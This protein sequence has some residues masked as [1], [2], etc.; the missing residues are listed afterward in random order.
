MLI[1]ISP[2]KTLDFESALPDALPPVT[3][4]EFS[5]D[6]GRLVRRLRELDTDSVAGLMHLSPALARLNVERYRSWQ[7]RA[8]ASGGRQAVLAFRGDVYLGLRAED[9]D[10]AD[11]AFAQQ[12]LRILSGLYGVLRPLDAIQPH[13]VEMGTPLDTGRSRG[14]YAWWGKRIALALRRQAVA[15]GTTTLVNLASQEYFRAVDA[16]AL[17]LR[18]VTPVFKE[19]RAGTL[20]IVSFSAKR[21]RGAMAG[22]AIRGRITD[23]DEL[24]GFAE[25]GYRFHPELS[26][27]DDWVF[28]R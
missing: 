12:H 6:A 5:A 1:V 15:V 25:D 3:R 17:G 11:H 8:P 9:F 2:A 21:A 23:P 20:K 16:R 18:I 26:C 13:R 27:T 19:R 7:M 24:R 4:A 10:A 22:F 14:L 28:V